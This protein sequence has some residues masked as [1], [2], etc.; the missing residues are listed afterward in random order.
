[1][2]GSGGKGADQNI[3]LSM[4]AVVFYYRMIGEGQCVQCL[5]HTL[6]CLIVDGAFIVTL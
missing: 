3:Q 4:N 1:M 6:L 2:L 5:K